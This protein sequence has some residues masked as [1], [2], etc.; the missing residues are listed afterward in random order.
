M[1]FNAPRQCFALQ[2]YHDA[3]QREASTVS[4]ARG[5]QAS[6]FDWTA[7]LVAG[8]SLKGRIGK[9]PAGQVELHRYPSHDDSLRSIRLTTAWL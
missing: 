2:Y 3:L 9:L 5:S 6:T 8:Y 7:I 1:R 4:T